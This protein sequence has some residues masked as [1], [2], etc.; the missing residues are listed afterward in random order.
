M[1]SLLLRLASVLAMLPASAS[2]VT[3]PAPAEEPLSPDY[4]VVA[5]GQLVAVYTARTLDAPFA[6][7][8]WDFGG[9]HSFA[10]F[11]TDGPIEAR[12]LCRS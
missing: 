2:V 10:N 4:Q 3:A 7:K 9:P 12:F 11:V 8:Q 6:G 1:N 5:G